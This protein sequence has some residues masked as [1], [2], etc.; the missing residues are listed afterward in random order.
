VK[1]NGMKAAKN[2][3]VSSAATINSWHGGASRGMRRASAPL[4]LR[5]RACLTLLRRALRARAAPQQRLARHARVRNNRK[6]G[7]N[8]LA[9]KIWRASSENRNGEEMKA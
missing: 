3:V 1:N 5:Q 8:E 2:I 4:A 6:H 7:I 9:R